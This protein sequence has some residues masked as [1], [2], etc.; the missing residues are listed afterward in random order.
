MASLATD[1]V[2]PNHNTGD[3]AISGDITQNLKSLQFE[4]ALNED[5]KEF[6]ILK[7]RS[8]ALTVAACAQAVYFVSLLNEA[9]YV[10]LFSFCSL[11]MFHPFV[12]V[13]V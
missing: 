9:R 11:S 8:H 5:E 6:M 10:N 1:M 2:V 7:Q 3:L 12:G 13:F 4:Y